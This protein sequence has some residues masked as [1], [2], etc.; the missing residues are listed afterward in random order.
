[1]QELTCH[2]YNS[3]AWCDRFSVASVH[4]MKVLMHLKQFVKRKS[5]EQRP[6]HPESELG[7]NRDEPSATENATEDSCIAPLQIHDRP[8][9]Y[10]FPHGRHSTDEQVN[11]SEKHLMTVMHATWALWQ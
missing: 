3:Y 10:W 1:M 9:W 11:P 7:T 6:C 4:L 2:F 8:I 5:K